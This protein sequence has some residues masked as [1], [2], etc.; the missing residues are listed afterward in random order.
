MNK[1]TKIIV[2]ITGI[3]IVLLALVGI[4]YGYFLTR[5]R[6]N[7]NPSSV[8]LTT[9]NLELT[10]DD[11][12]NQIKLEKMDYLL[13]WDDDEYPVACLKDKDGKIEWVNQN[14]VIDH[15]IAFGSAA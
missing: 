4:T 2:S 13:F 11:M 14:N 1:K 5:I 6:G 9:A 7:D 3:T 12:S 15:I 10:Y 8:L